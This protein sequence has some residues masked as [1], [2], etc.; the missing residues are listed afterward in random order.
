M[1]E[2]ILVARDDGGGRRKL[3]LLLA[4]LALAGLTALATAVVLLLG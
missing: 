4:L 1:G 3:P 2:P